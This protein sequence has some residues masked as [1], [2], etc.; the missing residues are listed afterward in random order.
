VKLLSVRDVF[1]VL[2]GF[3]KS[4][5]YNVLSFAYDLHENNDSSITVL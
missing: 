1:A 5:S 4:L 2:P 3:G